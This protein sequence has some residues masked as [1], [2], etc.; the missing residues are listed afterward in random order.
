LHA[1]RRRQTAWKAAR[2]R[3]EQNKNRLMVE[4][5][6]DLGTLTVDPMRLRQI[7]LNLLT[8]RRAIS[9]HPRVEATGTS[10]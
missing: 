4:A 6:G 7:L 3:A 9:R 5:A 8:A 1:P 10:K 2:Q